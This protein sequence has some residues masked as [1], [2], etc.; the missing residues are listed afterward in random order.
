MVLPNGSKTGFEQPAV[1]LCPRITAARIGRATLTATASFW[2]LLGDGPVV[3]ELRRYRRPLLALLERPA[4]A[5]SLRFQSHLR[6]RA[7]NWWLYAAGMLL[8]VILSSDN[9]PDG[10]TAL[11]RGASAT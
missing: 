6:R 3:Q 1:S 10:E 5:S 9:D 7:L 4:V 11:A 2:L 8:W